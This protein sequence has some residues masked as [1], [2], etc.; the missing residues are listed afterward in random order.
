MLGWHFAI[1]VV[2]ARQLRIP[3][4]YGLLRPLGILAYAAIKLN[5]AYL[6]LSGRGMAWKGRRYNE[7]A[8]QSPEAG[9]RQT[10][11]AVSDEG[12]TSRGDAAAPVRGRPGAAREPGPGPP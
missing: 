11:S 1:G 8:L 4:V 2:L 9:E 7:A 12:L 6:L 10:A 5:A 3:P